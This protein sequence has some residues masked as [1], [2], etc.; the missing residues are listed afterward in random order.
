MSAGDHRKL[1]HSNHLNCCNFWQKINIFIHFSFFFFF[2]LVNLEQTKMSILVKKFLNNACFIFKI[3]YKDDLM[4]PWTF[5]K[6]NLVH[7]IITGALLRIIFQSK[8]NHLLN[9]VKKPTIGIS[10]KK[11]CVKFTFHVQIAQYYEWTPQH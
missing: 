2:I 9:S 11:L 5:F 1:F 4:R 7:I 6:I 10:T 8:N 3:K